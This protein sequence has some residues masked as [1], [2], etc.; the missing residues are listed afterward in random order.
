V[1]ADDIG[2][3]AT[4]AA[5]EDAFGGTDLDA[6][7]S[8]EALVAMATAITAGEW[9]GA[10][11]APAVRVEAA[12]AAA[13]SS[14]T[15]STGPVVLVRLAGGQHTPGT[16]THELAHALA[17]VAAGHDGV[18]RAAHVD[19]VALLAGAGAAAD[20]VR[21]YASAGLE[22]GDR[23]WPSPVRVMGDGFAII[24]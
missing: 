23:R 10:C 2:R 1:N 22:V 19:V 16:L 12:S 5:E 24:P 21:A 6:E 9:W 20:L 15:R 11:G 14:S 18:F 13:H 7:S 8:L 17:G 3:A 4:Y